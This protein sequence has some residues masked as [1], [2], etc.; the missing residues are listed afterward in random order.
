MRLL[1]KLIFKKVLEMGKNLSQI[2]MLSLEELY[3]IQ[4]KTR[5]PKGFGF[6]SRNITFKGVHEL[7]EVHTGWSI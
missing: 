7:F 2:E 4:Y 1:K 6:S 3:S 5:T